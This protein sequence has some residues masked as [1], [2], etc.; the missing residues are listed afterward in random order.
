MRR[1]L[2]GEAGGHALGLLLGRRLPTGSSDKHGRVR[3]GQR[4]E[5][6]VENYTSTGQL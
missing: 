4:V 1:A 6:L 2:T 5:Y 3:A